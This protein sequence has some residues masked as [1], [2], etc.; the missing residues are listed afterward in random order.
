MVRRQAGAVDPRH[1]EVFN[2]PNL[3]GVLAGHIHRPSLDVV[4]GVPQIVAEA[5]AE[6]G[7]LD[8]ELLSRRT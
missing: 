1:R 3:L 2:T 6:G 8:V 7:Y 5:N 4:N